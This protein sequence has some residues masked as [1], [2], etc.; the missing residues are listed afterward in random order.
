MMAL[1]NVCLGIVVVTGTLAM[2]VGVASMIW[3]VIQGI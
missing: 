2:V 3:H 1:M